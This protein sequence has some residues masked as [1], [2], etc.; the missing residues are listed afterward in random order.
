MK[1]TTQ[2][3]IKGY[4]RTGSAVDITSYDFEKMR[5]FLHAHSLEKIAYSSGVYG[6]NGGIVQDRESGELYAITARNSA[7]MMVF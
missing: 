4:V 6:I 7:L 5:D 3:T 2:S 1:K